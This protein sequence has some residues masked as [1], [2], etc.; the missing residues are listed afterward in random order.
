MLI[1]QTTLDK[2]IAT[3]LCFNQRSKEIIKIK[4]VLN[5]LETNAQLAHLWPGMQNAVYRIMYII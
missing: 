3:G 4:L 1:H 2:R 5:E